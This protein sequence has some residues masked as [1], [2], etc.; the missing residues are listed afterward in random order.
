MPSWPARKLWTTS[1][2][3]LLTASAPELLE[4]F[5]GLRCPGNH[6][7]DR[8]WGTDLRALQVWT[9]NFAERLVEGCKRLK[10]AHR[11]S[12]LY[13]K[14]TSISAGVVGATVGGVTSLSRPAEVST[15][16]SSTVLGAAALFPARGVGPDDHEEP[17]ADED[18]NPPWRKCQGCRRCRGQAQK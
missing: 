3:A 8:T 13:E 15:A 2:E 14:S 17:V 7:H 12:I 11:K 10:Q 5:D 16:T 4:P 6:Q 1:Q 18:D 9:W